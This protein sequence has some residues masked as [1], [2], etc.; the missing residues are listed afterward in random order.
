MVSPWRRSGVA[1]NAFPASVSMAS[2][3]FMP[4]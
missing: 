1:G 2:F 4:A 3:L